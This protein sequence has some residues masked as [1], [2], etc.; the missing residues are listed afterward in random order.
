MRQQKTSKKNRTSYTYYD[1]DGTKY[2][3]KPGEDGV[4]EVD[5]AMLHQMDDDEFNAERRENYHVPTY[6]EAAQYSD[7][8]DIA[9][10]NK[11]LSDESANPEA[12]FFDA[13]AHAESNAA[14]NAIWNELLPQQR[15][16]IVKK[17]LKRSNVDIAAEE[18][19]SEAAIRKRLKKIQ[20]KFK[21]FR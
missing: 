7:G 8:T 17:L 11:R 9:D 5:I 16:L 18:G 2:Q 4:T 20:D 15:D 21:K 10:H 13:A 6:L 3:I 12:V 14:I 19:V 1:A